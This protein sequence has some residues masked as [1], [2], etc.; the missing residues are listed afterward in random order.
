M[1]E[2]LLIGLLGALVGVFLGHRLTISL[3]RNRT[4]SLEKAFYN[5]FEIIRVNFIK[6]KLLFLN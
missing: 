4:N 6:G 1:V 5:E 2:N 3:Y